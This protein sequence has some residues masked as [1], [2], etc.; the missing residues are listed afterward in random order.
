MAHSDSHGHLV[1]AQGLFRGQDVCNIPLKT[2][3]AILGIIAA[4]VAIVNTTW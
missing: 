1:L 3:Y 4:L 2:S